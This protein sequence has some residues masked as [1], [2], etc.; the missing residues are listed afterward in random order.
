MS[1]SRFDTMSVCEATSLDGESDW[2]PAFE[3]NIENGVSFTESS[4]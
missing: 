3:G 1:F 2:A 4:L